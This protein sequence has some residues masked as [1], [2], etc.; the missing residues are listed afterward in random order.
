MQLD[1]DCKHGNNEGD[2]KREMTKMGQQ[3]FEAEA[4]VVDENTVENL[5]LSTKERV[6][7]TPKVHAIKYHKKPW[8]WDGAVD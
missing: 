6:S 7:C 8:Q 5:K 4:E 1:G 2:L 3:R